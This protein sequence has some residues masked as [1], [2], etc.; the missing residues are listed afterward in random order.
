MFE[1]NI[2]EEHTPLVILFGPFASGKTSALYR[3]CQWFR[4]QGYQVL[5]VR[6]F[7][8]AQDRHYSEFCD[9]FSNWIHD[10]IDGLH[11]RLDFTLVEVYNQ[12]GRKLCLIMDT[13]GDYCFHTS[14]MNQLDLS[15]LF[16][17]NNPKAFL[18]FI[19]SDWNDLHDRKGYVER[20]RE[21]KLFLSPKDKSV[22]LYNKVDRSP[23]LISPGSVNMRGVFYDTKNMYPGL[24]ET[25]KNQSPITRLFRPYNCSLVPFS[26]GVFY[27]YNGRICFEPSIDAY[28][29]N[30]WKEI[31][32]WL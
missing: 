11:L 17:F 12:V 15:T 20:I 6:S 25:F 19:E 27:E 2:Y 16:Q 13:P 3:L 21:V 10:R 8:P 29:S 31:K 5:P 22:V 4:L 24:L 32:H 30:L 1:M 26:S 9:R 7:K 28:P 18:F 23:F 14:R